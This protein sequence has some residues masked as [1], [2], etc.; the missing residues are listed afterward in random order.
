MFSNNRLVEYIADRMPIGIYEDEEKEFSRN[1]IDYHPEDMIYL[2]SDGYADQFGGPKRKK[3][4]SSA[5]KSLL[6]EIG[7]MSLDSQLK[8]IES[9][10]YKW[11]GD[12]P[13]TDDVL[14]LGLRLW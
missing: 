1:E 13:Q 14:I 11:K 7:G 12:E 2:F 6:A 10:F 5:F 9:E 4:K 8:R 3:F